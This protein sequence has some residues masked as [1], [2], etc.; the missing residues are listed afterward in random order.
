MVKCTAR[1]LLLLG[2]S[3]CCRRMFL[4][5]DGSQ[6]RLAGAD[7]LSKRPQG[8]DPRR[9]RRLLEVPVGDR[10][11]N[12]ELWSQV[13][14]GSS[15]WHQ[16]VLEDNGARRQVS[17]MFASCEILASERCIT[18]HRLL[19]PATRRCTWD[20]R[21]RRSFRAASQ[22]AAATR[23]VTEKVQRVFDKRPVTRQRAAAVHA[24]GGHG[25]MQW[26]STSSRSSRAEV[27]AARGAA[28][29]TYAHPAEV[30]L[31]E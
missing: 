23:S 11:V 21:S 8:E 25:D 15:H 3:A 18:P 5:A 30:V 2:L 20:R 12:D 17:G 14:N 7:A 10:Y 16:T 13:G 6:D 22:A 4:P 9:V 27:G 31:A 28:D 1:G 29:E 24:P 19:L 26:L